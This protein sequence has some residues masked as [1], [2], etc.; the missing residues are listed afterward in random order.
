MLK[1]K[2]FMESKM[3]IDIICKKYKIENYSINDDGTVDVYGDVD[4]YAMNL[5][6][7]PLK[8]GKVTGEFQC[9][10]NDL[11]SLEGM[12]SELIGSFYVYANKL[13][14]LVGCP[15]EIGGDFL[16]NDNLLTNLEGGPVSVGGNFDCDKNLLTTL[17]GGPSV[18]GGSYRCNTNKLANL[19]GCPKTINDDFQCINNELISLEGSP[20]R[21]DGTFLCN[22]NNLSSLVGGPSVV[23]GGYSCSYNG[24]SD[25]KGAPKVLGGEYFIFD[26]NDVVSFVGFPESHR[27]D[28]SVWYDSNPIVDMTEHFNFGLDAITHINE[29]GVID[30]EEM[31]VSY[32]ALCE[33]WDVLGMEGMDREDIEMEFYTLVD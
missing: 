6:K 20:S 25:F 18:V 15:S 24:L 26:Y 13:K 21:I 14:S 19:S 2:A 1:Y 10:E 3:D 33:V 30:P 12:P 17:S 31:E 32:G 5:T 27:K 11:I 7:L 16:C 29:W 8:F 9:A 28:L 23:H 4:L 22:R